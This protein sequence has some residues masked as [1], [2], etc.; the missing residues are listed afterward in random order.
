M[1]ATM[2]D[3]EEEARRRQ[4]DA[5]APQQPT[6]EDPTSE[7]R[8]RLEHRL[9]TLTRENRRLRT[10]SLTQG[11][12]EGSAD[13]PDLNALLR[14]RISQLAAEVVNMTILLEGEDSPIAKAAAGTAARKRA[15]DAE[16][17]P[18]VSLADRVRAL[19]QAA[20]ERSG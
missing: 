7:E 9:T 11:L 12:A 19:R 6:A 5:A 4:G 14:E 18:V 3:R 10:A 15:V 13:H 17:K 20:S 16:G 2:A 1:L 8:R